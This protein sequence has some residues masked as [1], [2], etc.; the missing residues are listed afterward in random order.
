M[1]ATMPTPGRGLAALLYVEALERLA[2]EQDEAKRH[3]KVI[4]LS[5]GDQVLEIPCYR[6]S[7]KTFAQAK[8]GAGE[9]VMIL[10]HPAR[11]R[12]VLFPEL[13]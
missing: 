4:S 3:I 10:Q 11:E 5:V 8:C 9:S 13:F 6:G 1:N 7:L 2:K 12:A